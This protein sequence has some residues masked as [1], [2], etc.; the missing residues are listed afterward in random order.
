VL[1]HVVEF[2]IKADCLQESEREDRDKIA[3][4]IEKLLAK[5][6]LLHRNGIT[7]GGVS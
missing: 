2:L 7:F 4:G 6:D 1:R 3:R 5:L